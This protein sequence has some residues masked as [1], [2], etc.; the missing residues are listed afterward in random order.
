MTEEQAQAVLDNHAKDLG[1]YFEHVLI[2]ACN[3]EG[4]IV[5]RLHGGA[6]N[7]YA[8]IGMA[9]EFLEREKALIHANV[10]DER[11]RD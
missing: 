4:E 7:Y 2:I 10:Q 8:W 11:D 9:H 1:E 3:R 6:G 5:S